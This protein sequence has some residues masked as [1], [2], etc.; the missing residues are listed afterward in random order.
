MLIDQLLADSHLAMASQLTPEPPELLG[1]G[2]G[3]GA[4][5]ARRCRG[6]RLAGA[7]A[8][9]AAAAAAAARLVPTLVMVGVASVTSVRETSS[10]AP[11]WPLVTVVR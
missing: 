11:F 8:A 7:A 4:G 3:A 2:A 9:G 10:R 5:A 6:G 1:A